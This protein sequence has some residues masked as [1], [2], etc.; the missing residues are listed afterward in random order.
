MN[1]SIIKINDQ[2]CTGC[3]QCIPNCPEGAIQMIDGK[4]RLISD[5][6]CDG[7]GACL[8]HC[9]VGA[10]T[11]EQREAEPYDERRVMANV[12]RQGRN[13][14]KAHL[15]HL[16][17]HGQTDYLMQAIEYL[18][19]NG[20]V[21]PLTEKTSASNPGHGPAGGGCPG[22]RAATFQPRT[23]PRAAMDNPVASEL[24]H[25]PLQLHLI[26]PQAA[27]YQGADVLLSADCVAYA[28]GDFHRAHLKGKALAIACPK[29]DD[30]QDVYVAK[31][32][33]LID[34]AKINTLTVL[35]MQV[36]CCSGLLRIAQ[37]AAQSAT[38][39]VPV[40]AMVISLQGEVL[41]E[42]WV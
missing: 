15:E 16:R 34:E 4:A 36:P 30:G 33:A 25:W 11:I 41:R 32:R 22:S 12:T 13:V 8:G 19:E 9:P 37:Q 3:G 23:T 18:N 28:M 27:Q 24:T 39:K 2:T 42:E 26:S 14:I 1:R 20:I 29:L 31:I 35:I 7:L 10:I 6:F 5:L 38:R 21:N 17:D 40:K